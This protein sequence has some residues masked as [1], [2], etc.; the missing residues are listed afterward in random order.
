MSTLTAAEQLEAMINGTYVNE[1]IQENT[2]VNDE[3]TNSN[4]SEDLDNQNDNSNDDVNTDKTNESENDDYEDTDLDTGS[5]EEEETEHKDDGSDE[6]TSETDEKILPSPGTPIFSFVIKQLPKTISCPGT[7]IG[8]PEDGDK[9]FFVVI[10][11][12][13]ASSCA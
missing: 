1:D 4:D 6:D 3:E 5:D 12:I 7:V 2:S 11:S 10:I 13:F 9:I 8:F